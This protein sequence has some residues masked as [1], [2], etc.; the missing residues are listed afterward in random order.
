VCPYRALDRGLLEDAARRLFA[1]LPDRQIHIVPAPSLR[2]DEIR[3]TLMEALG[4]ADLVLVYLQDKLGGEVSLSATARSPELAFD[5]TFVELVPHGT[6]ITV[7]RYAILELQTMDFHGTYRFVVKNLED[8]LRL[9]GPGFP[10][11]L[12]ENPGWLSERVEGPNVANVFK[13][14]FYQ[15]VLKFQIAGHGECVGSVLA[16]PASVWNSWQRHLGAP[17]LAAEMDGTFSLRRPGAASTLGHARAWIYVF[18]LDAGNVVS[19][20]PV[21]I[22]RIIATDAESIAYYALQA[23]PHAAM[24]AGGSA[25]RLLANIRRRLQVWWPDVG[26]AAASTSQTDEDANSPQ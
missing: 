14:T 12:Q 24:E 1:A 11:A 26:L 10:R 2:R 6:S 20:N 17:E 18:D 16:I 21:N 4:N 8:A 15:T 5:T 7:G 19:P 3:Q 22:T 23:A 25:D 13:R 9:H